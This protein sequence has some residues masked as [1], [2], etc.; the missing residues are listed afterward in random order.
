MATQSQMDAMFGTGWEGFNLPSTAPAGQDPRIEGLS[1]QQKEN[2]LFTGSIAGIPNKD[3]D[4][5]AIK[6]AADPNRVQ[7]LD[8]NDPRKTQPIFH[9]DGSI[10]GY[11]TPQNANI[12]AAGF[13]NNQDYDPSNPGAGNLVPGG[14]TTG[15]AAQ[16]G[17]MGFRDPEGHYGDPSLPN[18]GHADGL[19]DWWQE[20]GEAN[21]ITWNDTLQ[22]MGWGPSFMDGDGTSGD[23]LG[24]IS[25]SG[26][27]DNQYEEAQDQRDVLPWDEFLEGGGWKDAFGDPMSGPDSPTQ[28]GGPADPDRYPP[29]SDINGDG[30]VNWRDVEGKGWGGTTGG[31][32]SNFGG[33][34]GTNVT[35]L[36]QITQELPD[37]TGYESS[38]NKDFY[39]K[40]FQEMRGQ[41]MGQKNADFKSMLAAEM[42]AEQAK[43]N[44]QQPFGGDPW[45][46]ADLP[47]VVEGGGSMENGGAPQISWGLNQGYGF[48]PDTT[49]QQVAQGM[50]GILGTEGNQYMNDYFAG[51]PDIAAGTDWTNAGSRGALNDWLPGTGIDLAS[52]FGQTLDKTFNNI[53]TKT[54]TAGS[55]PQGQAIPAGYASPTNL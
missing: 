32:G 50:S 8:P 15:A 34:N 47:T 42:R 2:L 1:Q 19:Y 49:N 54:A 4:W 40:Q 52:P 16:Y 18:Y 23:A 13:N 53:Y 48:T 10:I 45:S 51:H 21:G 27:L 31:G 14:N 26:A 22:A 44:P 25:N 29:G 7:M 6:D 43:A 46:W 30:K 11:A 36:D 5:D 9:S 20:H 35:G 38:T 17:Q 37:L 24:R 33:N 3:P 12:W 55:G 41:Q 39:Q 28:G